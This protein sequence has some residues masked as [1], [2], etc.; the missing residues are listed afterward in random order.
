MQQIIRKFE[1]IQN[2]PATIVLNHK[3]FG[4][5]VCNVDKFDFI[6]TNDK[7]GVCVRGQD[8]YICKSD[9]SEAKVYNDIL[10]FSDKRFKI[11]INV[12]K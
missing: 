4:K 11:I 3:L 10:M 1:Q 12:K 2:K 8:I 5:Q 9:I 7:L 6:N